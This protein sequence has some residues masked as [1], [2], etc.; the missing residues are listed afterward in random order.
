MLILVACIG[1]ADSVFDLTVTNQSNEPVDIYVNGKPFQQPK[2]LVAP[3]TTHTFMAASWAY[4]QSIRI[5]ARETSGKILFQTNRTPPPE[6]GIDRVN[7]T[8]PGKGTD[9]CSTIK[10]ESGPLGSIRKA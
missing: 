5:E 4:S 3:C 7:L 8:V 2:N 10:T 6:M 9:T 1:P